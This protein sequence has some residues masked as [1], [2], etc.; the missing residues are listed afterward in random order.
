MKKIALLLSVAFA[1]FA[2]K[3]SD[4]PPLARIPITNLKFSID[5]SIQP[6]FTYYIPINEVK[7]N[8][9][10]LLA[11][12]GIDTADI[13]SIRPSR[14]TMS[15]LFGNSNLDFIDAVSVRLCLPGD[16]KENCGRESF[17]RDPTPY[18]I[19]RELELVPSNV[20]DI[21]EMVLQDE[22]NV[23]VKLERLRD[24]PQ[25]SFDVILDMEFEV[26]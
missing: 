20:N 5:P 26:R 10:A 7:P 6:P 21:R 15:V 22:I 19:G 8:A 2:C 11:S 12:K 16:N 24:L 3:K 17:Y 25:G 18:D 4:L 13:K 1:F 9:L 14:A 23:Q